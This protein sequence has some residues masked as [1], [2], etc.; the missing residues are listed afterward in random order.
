MVPWHTPVLC[1]WWPER[2]LKYFLGL[3]LTL[4]LLWKLS[5]KKLL[6]LARSFHR[7]SQ[8]TEPR[9]SLRRLGRDIGF[10]PYTFPEYAWQRISCLWFLCSEAAMAFRY[11]V[12][13]FVITLIRI[14]PAIHSSWM[15]RWLS[16]R[17]LSPLDLRRWIISPSLKVLRD[18]F[19]DP[20]FFEEAA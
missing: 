8:L 5:G 14:F 11:S 10:V 4:M 1:C 9:W 12:R 15:T 3:T 2:V 17:R 13:R 7:P 16:Q 20:D 19:C 18:I 6:A